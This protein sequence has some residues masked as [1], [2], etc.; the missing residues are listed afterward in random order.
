MQTGITLVVA[1]SELKALMCSRSEQ[2]PIFQ[3]LNL[4]YLVQEVYLFI[5]DYSVY[6]PTSKDFTV[7]N[8]LTLLSQYRLASS[9]HIGDYLRNFII[10]HQ[11]NSNEVYKFVCELCYTLF[12]DIE[13]KLTQHIRHAGYGLEYLS[14][15]VKYSELNYS[16]VEIFHYGYRNNT[17]H[18]HYPA[19]YSGRHN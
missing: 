5:L 14:I 3:A 10:T 17:P 8:P 11:F 18:D 2:L 4:S 7:P 19:I 12:I 13:K 16:V 15:D 9:T 1:H 6:D